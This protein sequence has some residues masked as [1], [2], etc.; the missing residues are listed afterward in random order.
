MQNPSDPKQF[1]WGEVCTD[2][3]A[4]G[5]SGEVPESKVRGRGIWL[6]NQMKAF[7]IGIFNDFNMNE[8]IKGW[9]YATTNVF[10][11]GAE[12]KVMKPELIGRE[13]DPSEV[14]DNDKFLIAQAKAS[15]E[16]MARLFDDETIM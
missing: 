15:T 12:N 16:K 6:S 1:W 5:E 10:F 9:R 2:L 7:R 11:I 3:S 14:F 4:S 8:M 13:V